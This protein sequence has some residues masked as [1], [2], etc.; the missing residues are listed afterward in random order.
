VLET[1]ANQLRA[2][3]LIDGE[4]EVTSVTRRSDPDSP[5][6]DLIAATVTDGHTYLFDPTEPVWI[7]R[8]NQ[9]ATPPAAD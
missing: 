7:T 2:G 6:P 9:S 1:T 5:A 8:P 3:D 4:E